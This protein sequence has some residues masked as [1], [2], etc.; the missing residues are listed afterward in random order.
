MIEHEDEQDFLSEGQKIIAMMVG[1]CL[2]LYPIFFLISVSLHSWVLLPTV[3][4]GFAFV[5]FMIWK[6]IAMN[7][8]YQSNQ[9][10]RRYR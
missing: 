2:S 3:I 9:N 7:G 10:N 1:G 5:W 6:T 4:S 8:I